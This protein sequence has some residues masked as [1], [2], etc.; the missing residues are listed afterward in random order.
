[1]KIKLFSYSSISLL[2]LFIALFV[3]H[4]ITDCG[5]Y[6]Q[7][8]SIVLVVE[9]II[10]LIL[11][12]MFPLMLIIKCSIESIVASYKKRCVANEFSIKDLMGVILATYGVYAITRIILLLL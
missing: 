3:N 11:T 10:F 12:L 9:V 4:C 8:T 5:I 6:E 7:Q 2:F 1:M